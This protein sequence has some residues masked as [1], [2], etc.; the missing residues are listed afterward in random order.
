MDYSPPGSSVLGGVS[1]KNIAVG[2]H[3]SSNRLGRPILTTEAPE[4]LQFNS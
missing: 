2:C 4:K 1:G 3:S